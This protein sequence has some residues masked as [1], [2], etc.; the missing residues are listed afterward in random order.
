MASVSLPDIPTGEELEDYV[1]AFLQ[2]GGFYTEKSLI[3]RGETEVLELDI[4]AWKPV[5]QPPQHTLFEVK[6]GSWGFSDVFKVYG[7]KTYLQTRG[8][9]AAYLIA[10]TGAKEPKTIEYMQE[11]CQN[12][13]LSLITHSDLPTL[14]TN[15]AS[16]SLAV[17]PTTDLDHS[18]WRFSFW[19]ERQMQKVVTN[20]R[21]SQKHLNS[22]NE[23][24]AYQEKI[25]NG[26][27]QAQGVR[28]RLATL[29]K[30]HLDHRLLAMS[31]AA[32][33]DGGAWNTVNPPSG[34]HWRGAL[35]HCKYPLVHAAMY[36]QHRARLDILK[37]A[38]EYALLERHGALP[39]SRTI[40]ALWTG[41]P[42]GSLPQS[43]HNAVREMQTMEGFEKLAVLWQSFCGSGEGFFL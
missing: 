19:L 38:V 15:L 20:G 21:K 17:N 30:A 7:W 14:R 12:I 13:G 22:P 2:C 35:N 3:E 37:G 16:L 39:P 9:N 6:G 40:S 27:L 25:R 26:F 24:Y 43:F 31:V 5:D 34:V 23:I 18:I 4:M 1:A 36:Y 8:V 41:T 11:K 42:P 32:E 10:P 33:L 28:E 29:Y